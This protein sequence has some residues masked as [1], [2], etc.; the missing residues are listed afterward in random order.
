[1]ALIAVIDDD[2]N[3]CRMLMD[4]FQ[5]K[6]HQTE[7]FLSGADALKALQD[8]ENT[9]PAVILLDVMMPEL[10]GYTVYTKLQEDER[11]RQVPIVI[12]TAKGRTRSLFESS[13]KIAAFVE[14]PVVLPELAKIVAKAIGP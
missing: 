6:G 9:L 14:K 13:L 1:M 5:L 8:P 11:T 4:F 10:D 2:F 3:F 7:A 12:L